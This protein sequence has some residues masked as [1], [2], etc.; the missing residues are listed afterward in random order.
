MCSSDLF[1]ATQG[2]T[3]L[4]TGTYSLGATPRNTIVA[5]STDV[6]WASITG[7]GLTP[8]GGSVTVNPSGLAAGTYTGNAVFTASDALN[9]PYS[10]PI[11]LTITAPGGGVLGTFSNGASF[12][13]GNISPNEIVSF[14]AADLT[15]PSGSPSVTING[16]SAQV[17]GAAKS[18]INFTVPQ[19][20]GVSGAALIQVSCGTTVIAS[21]SATF[22]P[23]APA[24]FTSGQSGA[25]QGAILN[26]DGAFNGSKPA[27][28]GSIVSVYV[29]GFGALNAP[30]SDG[31]RRLAGTVTATVGGIPA[32]VVYSGE[33]PGFT[34]GLQQINVQIPANVPAGSLPIVLTING[35]STQ[36]GVTLAI[37]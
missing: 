6:P 12:G 10:L 33:A 19:S 15:C 17:L 7:G 31:L 34:T 37:Q 18:Q 3:A 1:T 8:F 20:A 11:T 5:V 2:A 21:A 4:L 22:A 25:G 29:T 28:R 16:V 27:A 36:V 23:Q 14:F 32:T 9:S 13:Q 24:I 26:Q 35:V 30:G